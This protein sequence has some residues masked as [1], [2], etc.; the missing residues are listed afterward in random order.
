MAKI[1]MWP[2]L[3]KEHGHWMPCIALAGSLKS[4]H[5]VAFMGIPDCASIVAPYHA[6]F[7]TVL[8]KVYPP[9]YSL[10]NTLEPLGQRW[11]PEHLTAITRGALDDIFSTGRDERPDVLISGYFNALETLLIYW[12]YGVK[13][14]TMTTYLRH[15]DDDP[16]IL[17]KTKLVY[18]SRAMARHLIDSVMVGSPILDAKVGMSIDEFV[19][20]LEKALE[21]ICCAKEFDFSDPDWAHTGN[22][23]YVEP[24][25]ERVKLDATGGPL[26]G[27]ELVNLPGNAKVIFA[28]SGSQV[29][30]YETRAKSFFQALIAM[31]K[32]PGMTGYDLVL[33]VGDKLFAEFS[34]EYGIDVGKSTLPSNVHLYPWVSQLDVVD[35]AHVV[36]THGGLATLKE[37]IWSQVPIVIVPH[38]KDQLD[39]SL[40]LERNGLGVVVQQ[41]GVTPDHLRKMLTQA[42]GSTWIRNNLAK[43]RKTFEVLETSKPSLEKIQQVIAA[44]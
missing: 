34:V 35:K 20:P 11:K 10:E 9:G 7:H 39:N 27:S 38:G 24:M 44:T 13:I 25:I 33:A 37:A 28:S 8:P 14:I 40:R 1:L 42:T 32:M 3:Y 12:K 4:N 22:V 29:Q 23:H 31:T 43:M 16:A 18:M 5:S 2:D 21:L 15:P 6:V 36:F 26:S 30:D 41:E 17:A 19:K